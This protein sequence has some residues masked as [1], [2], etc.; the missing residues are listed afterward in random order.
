VLGAGAKAKVDTSTLVL[1]AGAKAKVD[2]STLVL[3]AGAK[4]KGRRIHASARCWC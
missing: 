3:G 4:A 1:G 2:T